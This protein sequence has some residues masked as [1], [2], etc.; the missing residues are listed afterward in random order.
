MNDLQLCNDLSAIE[1]DIAYYS[2]STQRS[3]WEL[4]RRFK[5]VKENDLAHGKF[6]DWYIKL[7]FEKNF[8]SDAIKVA[9]EYTNFPTLGNFKSTT[10]LR[11]AVHI[12][13]EEREKEHTLSSGET[14]T[15]DDMTIRE[16]KELKQKIN[17]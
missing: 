13:A 9:T 7:G 8:V 15:V 2:H 10:A 11:L 4:G 14:K 12:P 17:Q 3:L 5:H 6:M 1:D 16:I